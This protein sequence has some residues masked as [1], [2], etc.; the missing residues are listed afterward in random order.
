[1]LG[2]VLGMDINNIDEYTPESVTS[3]MS[4]MVD[5]VIIVD[6]NTNRYRRIISR[7]FMD[8]FLPPNG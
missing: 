5:Q 4:E 1:M 7:G 6:S 2:G 8:E 3:L